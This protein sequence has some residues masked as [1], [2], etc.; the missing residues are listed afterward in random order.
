MKISRSFQNKDP[1]PLLCHPS[2][3]HWAWPS[4]DVTL[5]DASCCEAE[6]KFSLGSCSTIGRLDTAGGIA[7]STGKILKKP[8]RQTI[9]PA[10]ASR[11]SGMSSIK[12]C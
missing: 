3:R 7:T 2:R 6:H 10:L 8:M 9:D 11:L 5:A 12:G 1:A 4:Q